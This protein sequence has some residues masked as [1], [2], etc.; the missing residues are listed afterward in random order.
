MSLKGNV[1]SNYRLH[2]KLSKLETVHGRSAY[3]IAVIN[4]YEGTESEWLESLHGDSGY[5]IA[6]Q[7]GYIGTENDFVRDLT[8]FAPLANEAKAAEQNAKAYATNASASD[9]S[10]ANDA[11]AAQNAKT[12]AESAKA[13]AQ[14][15]ATK[16]AESEQK[17]KLYADQT[18]ASVSGVASF[19]GRGG[20]VMPQSGDYTAQMV[21]AAPAGYGWGENSK[22]INSTYD[23]ETLPAVNARYYWSASVPANAPAFGSDAAY[24]YVETIAASGR[25]YL[26]ART[27]YTGFEQYVQ[28]AYIK[29][30]VLSA[31]EW[32]NPPMQI[33][34]EYRT[35]ERFLGKPVYCKLVDFGKL[36]NASSKTV[37]HGV[38]GIY[39]CFSVEGTVLENG[40]N[41]NGLEGLSALYRNQNNI[42]AVTTANLSDL[43]AYVLMKY[44]KTTD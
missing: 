41:L 27:Q 5:E 4:G 25:T 43:T 40:K 1:K 2:G 14:Q 23:L 44:T 30:G 8:N 18:E 16:A 26:I 42:V 31:W 34:V 38:T 9:V 19:N 21:G 7:H 11:A 3:E 22:Q 6:K 12:A 10:A 29:N 32:V 39:Q 28:M 13:A 33:G 15:S 24:G 17:A 37:G 20:H 36:P 35:T